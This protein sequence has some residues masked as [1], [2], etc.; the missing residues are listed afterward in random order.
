MNAVIKF[1][2]K[3]AG[4]FQLAK[5]KADAEGNKIP[6][7]REVVA[8]WFPNLI[9][10][11][12]L[13]RMGANADWMTFCQVGTGND[14]PAFTDV[15][16]ETFLAGSG[17]FQSNTASNAPSSPYYGYN[18]RVWQF[19]AGVATGNISEIGVG[20]VINGANLFSRALILDGGGSPTTITILADEILETS[21]EFRTY[22]PEIDTTGSFV[23]SG[24]TYDYT[25]RASNVTQSSQNAG[26]NG[27]GWNQADIGGSSSNIKSGTTAHRAFVGALGAITGEPAGASAASTGF[28]SA[29][30]VP[31]S[32][33][34]DGT[35]IWGISATNI[36]SYRCLRMSWRWGSYQFEVDPVIPKT[37]INTL[38]ITI[39]HSWGRATI[40]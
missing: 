35:A 22:P 3:H 28:S 18:I 30:Y 11:Q 32:L 20:W 31:G 38:S 14:T 40:P 29:A 2:T 37:T 7:T 27:G 21:Y 1:H 34:R 15:Q 4:F 5:Y 26:S 10:N 33:Q 6:G 12:G 16:L 17:S 8:D 24:I 25:A 36:G 9:V 19:A 13:E 23:I 39:R